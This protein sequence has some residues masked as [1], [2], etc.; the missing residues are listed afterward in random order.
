MLYFAYLLSAILW[1]ISYNPVECPEAGWVFAIPA[2]LANMHLKPKQNTW[3]VSFITCYVVWFFVLLWLRFVYPPFGYVTLVGLPAI[4]A[5]YYMPFFALS[6][7][8]LSERFANNLPKR[9]FAI[10]AFASFW[11]VLEFA[12]AN[13]MTGFPWLLL[14]HSQYTRPVLIQSA[15]I[16]GTYMVSFIVILFNIG[17]A[18]YINHLYKF[19]R[20][21]IRNVKNTG[22]FCPEFY[23]ATLAL[24]L[25]ILL[26]TKDLPLKA[27]S[28]YLF[29]AGTIQT[30]F[31]A[32]RKWDK[33]FILKDF[34]TIRN[35]S[36]ATQDARADILLF[37]EAATP[38]SLPLFANDYTQNYLEDLSKEIAM[39]ILAGST[40]IVREGEE[41]FWQNGIFTVSPT[42]GLGQDFYAKMQLVP[43][44]EYVPDIFSF[45]GKLVPVGNMKRGTHTTP[46]DIEITGKQYKI[47]TMICYEDIFEHLGRQM[48]N[49]GADLLFVCTNDSWYGR[50]AGAWQ[51]SAH[52]A[53]QAVATRKVLLRSSNNGLSC[54]FNEYGAML[55]SI[56]LMAKDGTAFDGNNELKTPLDIKD[57]S[58]NML[59]PYS[60]SPLKNSPLMNEQSDIYFRGAGYTDVYQFKNFKDKQ[61][62]YLKYG[63]KFPYLCIALSLAFAVVFYRSR[64]R[65]VL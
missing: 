4:I 32:F 16:G 20:N 12:R 36:L 39:P 53:L 56:T 54:V 60:L 45:L 34:E 48:A 52:S 21:K 31:V 50:E 51:H 14:G 64:K 26:Y 28:E 57:E 1:F 23:I 55:P 30:D 61:S 11:V 38:P 25:N 40:S 43:F 37:P 22:K 8:F 24:M 9:I 35:L 59:N 5:L 62:I 27:N 13:L 46:L 15:A 44:G 19:H 42:T 33:E 63:Y 49:N 65:L 41:V 7:Y 3:L 2:L 18:K 10:F 17:M 58:G 47:G 29:R 6:K